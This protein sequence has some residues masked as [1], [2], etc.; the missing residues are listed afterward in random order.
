MQKLFLLSRLLESCEY[1]E[2][3]ATLDG[4]DLCAD[5]V[6]DCVGFEELIRLRIATAVAQCNREISRE[7]LE[8]WLRLRGDSFD[9][10]VKGV[11]GW[12]IEG[13]GVKI[14]LNKDN[15]AKTTIT[16]ENVKFDRTGSPTL[17]G[18]LLNGDG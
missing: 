10:F 2:F 8:G 13:E 12:T 11:C 3:W 17:P 9:G 16:R 1:R 6:A 7:L 5:L 4:D 15:E 18:Q 14:P